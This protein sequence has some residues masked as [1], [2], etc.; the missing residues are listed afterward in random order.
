MKDKFSAVWV[1]YSSI[2]DYFKCPRLYYLRNIYRDPQNNKKIS[3]IEP[4]LATGQVIHEV[5]ESLSVKSFKERFNKS[6]LDILK[7]GWEKITGEKGGF[8]SIQQEEK[9]RIRAEKMIQNVMNHPG[10]LLNKTIR[11]R[12]DLPYY[13]L[14]E[15]DNIILCGKIDW[16]EYIEEYDSVRIIDF[17]TGKTDEDPDS[18]QLPIYL[19]LASNTQTKPI[20]GIS[21]WYLDRDNEPVGMPMPDREKSYV[22]IMEAA[23]KVAL[24]RKLGHF[25][26]RENGCR[27]CLPYE[28]VISGK[29]KQI[30]INDFGQNLYI[31]L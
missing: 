1:S 12:Q 19:L 16:L 25:K 2:S 22:R 24:A 27:A 26:C 5:L 4:P 17:K 30:G 29:A 28:A 21:Y 9:Y 20:T 15:E 11:I 7:V 18:L 23:K 3:L 14:S 10:P 8:T 13:W 31:L 6:L